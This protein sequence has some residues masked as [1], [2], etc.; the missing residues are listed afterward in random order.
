[1][2]S[3]RCDQATFAVAPP[4]F[5]PETHPILAVHFFGIGIRRDHDGADRFRLGRFAPAI[6]HTVGADRWPVDI[7]E[8]KG[9]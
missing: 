7:F 5:T 8:G 4:N 3:Q 2:N 9:S 6:L 1:M